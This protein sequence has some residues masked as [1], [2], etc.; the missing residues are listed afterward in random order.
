[1]KYVWIVGNRQWLNAL[2]EKRP[3]ELNRRVPVAVFGITA[4]PSFGNITLD[5][6]ALIAMVVYALVAWAIVKLVWLLFY[7]PISTHT[8]NGTTEKNDHKPASMA[9]VFSLFNEV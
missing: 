9:P 7:R 6:P 5:G 8:V 3:K 2:K 4:T 1:M